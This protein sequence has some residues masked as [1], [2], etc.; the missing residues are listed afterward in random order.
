M[1]VLR[2]SYTE[3]TLIV[4][5]FEYDT[6]SFETGSRAIDDCIESYKV[7]AEGDEEADIFV[8]PHGHDRDYD[9]ECICVQYLNDH[10]PVWSNHS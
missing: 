4:N 6:N 7:I 5:G 9:G 10:K 1:R 3:V 8:L 2:M